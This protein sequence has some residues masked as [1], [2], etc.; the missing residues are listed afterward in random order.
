MEED[1]WCAYNPEE[2]DVLKPPVFCADP[3]GFG[4]EE[5]CLP[6]WTVESEERLK[7]VPSFIRSMVRNAVERYAMENNYKEI[8][9]KVMEDVRNK[10]GAGGIIGH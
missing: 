9:P 6:L 8:T 3:P 5:R 1:P 2:G 7:R 4:S 10:M